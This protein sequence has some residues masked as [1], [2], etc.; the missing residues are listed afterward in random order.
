MWLLEEH[1]GRRNAPV[2]SR[3]FAS[4]ELLN[5]TLVSEFEVSLW[6]LNNEIWYLLNTDGRERC[7]TWTFVERPPVDY[8]LSTLAEVVNTK[9]SYLAWLET[10]DRADARLVAEVEKLITAYTGVPAGRVEWRAFVTAVVERFKL[11]RERADIAAEQSRKA[12]SVKCARRQAETDA[13]YWLDTG[14]NEVPATSIG[15]TV[16]VSYLIEGWSLTADEA[17]LVIGGLPAAQWSI[18]SAIAAVAG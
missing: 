16:L 1:E 4:K 17:A 6:G 11:Q 15:H 7:I 8:K 9:K 3:T 2:R 14:A 10:L 5:A 13:R 12:Y 18:C